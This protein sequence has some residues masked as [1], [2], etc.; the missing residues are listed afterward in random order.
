M[1]I[2]RIDL[3]TISIVFLLTTFNFALCFINAVAFSMSS[4]EV[5]A[6][7]AALFLGV[8]FVFIYREN[9]SSSYLFLYIIFSWLILSYIFGFGAQT[10]SFFDVLI[11]PLC[12]V[13]GMKCNLNVEAFKKFS[14]YV[15]VIAISTAFC[16]MIF[17]D[18]Y[19]DLLKVGEYY[20]NTR[21][22]VGDA[23]GASESDLYLGALRPEGSYISTFVHRV[24]GIFLEPL[25]F[26]YFLAC[27]PWIIRTLVSKKIYVTV[28]LISFIFI[29]ATDTRTS[30]VMFLVFLFIDL[31]NFKYRN[32]PAVIVPAVTLILAFA[33]YSFSSGEIAFRLGFNFEFFE[34]NSIL[35]LLGFG[36]IEAVK[37]DSGYALFIDYL[38]I[39]LFI[40]YFFLIGFIFRVN[41]ADYK[42]CIILL[43]IISFTFLFGAAII[44]AK[45]APIVAFSAGYLAVQRQRFGVE[46]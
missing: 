37:S 28:V 13:I 29:L 11:I 46:Q 41:S 4:S 43:F 30:I 18:V 35:S 44:S 6:F 24:S 38:G 36:V 21:E 1:R 16:E 32:V 26:S 45:I 5:V 19:I 7:Q 33:I 8:V 40:L 17:T 20:L 9:F 31:S 10:K 3:F 23:G 27:I 15:I 22:W 39:P 2:E 12:L 14:L 34:N 42:Y 25:T